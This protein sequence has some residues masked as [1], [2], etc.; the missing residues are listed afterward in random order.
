MYDEIMIMITRAMNPWE[1]TSDIK[2]I[3]LYRYMHVY[4]N[5]TK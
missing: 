5:S 4:K 3:T 2:R 1:N